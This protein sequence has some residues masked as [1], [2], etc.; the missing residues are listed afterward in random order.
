MKYGELP[1]VL[2][3]INVECLE[4][5]FYQYL[6]IKMIGE[7]KPEVEQRLSFLKDII[8][9]VCCHFVAEYGLDKYIE[10]YCYLTVKHQYQNKEKTFNRQGYHSDGFLTDDINYIWSDKSP[11]IFNFSDFKLTLD[12][13]VSLSEME[14]QAMPFNEKTFP[15]KTLLRLNQFNIHKVNENQDEGMRTFIKISFSKDKYDLIGNSHN[16]EL[17]YNWQMKERSKERN[18]PQSVNLK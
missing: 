18:I 12:D 8:G 14:E 11:T 17:D 9:C 6:P 7:S 13:K 15:N 10:S 16:Y 1:K 2:D 3:E 5:M 4:M